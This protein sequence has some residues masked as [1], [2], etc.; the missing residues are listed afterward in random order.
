MVT[1]ITYE[2]LSSPVSPIMS[3][4][5]KA[6]LLAVDVRELDDGSAPQNL[7]DEYESVAETVVVA[8]VSTTLKVNTLVEL[9]AGVTDWTGDEADWSYPRELTYR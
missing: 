2:G 1:L 6:E 9:T 4:A 5:E 8:D 7:F 3:G